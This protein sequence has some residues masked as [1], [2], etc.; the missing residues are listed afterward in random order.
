MTRS[1]GIDAHARRETYGVE[2]CQVLSALIGVLANPREDWL[3][4]VNCAMKFVKAST[5]VELF[6][7]EFALEKRGLVRIQGVVRG[8]FPFSKIGDKSMLLW[9]KVNVMNEIDKICVGR[10]EN[11]SEGTLEK[12]AVSLIEVV[13]RFGVRV[14]KI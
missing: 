5:S 11:P 13:V 7:Y 3:F 2:T 10:D 4:D 12:A 6:E 9:I 1:C 14:E 8:I